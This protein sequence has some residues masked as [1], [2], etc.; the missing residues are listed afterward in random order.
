MTIPHRDPNRDVPTKRRGGSTASG[1]PRPARPRPRCWG[2]PGPCGQRA[3]RRADVRPG[4]RCPPA[5]RAGS[6]AGPAAAGGCGGALHGRG[7][8]AGP[9]GWGHG[10]VRRPYKARRSAQVSGP[11]GRPGPAGRQPPGPEGPPPGGALAHAAVCADGETE[12]S[13]QRSGTLRG[14]PAVPGPL[15]GA[16]ERACGRRGGADSGA[17]AL[18]WPGGAAGGLT[19]RPAQR[20]SEPGPA[21][22][23]QGCRGS[24]PRW[25]RKRWDGASTNC[26]CATPTRL[27]M[28]RFEPRATSQ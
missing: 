14:E 27:H 18:P 11:R 3:A 1:A 25:E 23:W 24:C 21:G 16:G 15:R 4:W 9:G 28:D 19:P 17:A 7:T 5:E 6:G 20:G 22:P 10:S 12:R 26:L 2:E 13:G 8:A